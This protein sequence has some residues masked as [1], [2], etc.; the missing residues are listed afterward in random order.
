[1]R[2][3]RKA[4]ALWACVRQGDKTVWKIIKWF[5]GI[6]LVLGLIGSLMDKSNKNTKSTNTATNGG[7]GVKKPGKPV[8]VPKPE[9]TSKERFAKAK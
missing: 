3:E 5:F 2:S 8:E 7:V 4:T 1:M 9:L 6:I